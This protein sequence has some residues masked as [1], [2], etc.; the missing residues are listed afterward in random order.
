MNPADLTEPMWVLASFATC[1]ALLFPVRLA[2][3][4]AGVIDRPNARSSHG[5]PTIR[6]A[7][8]GIVLVVA[9]AT[10]TL[11]PRQPSLAAVAGAFVTLAVISFIDDLRGLPARVRFLAH[12]AAAGV[13]LAVVGRMA[14]VDHAAAGWVAGAAFAWVWIV[15][16]TN[17]FNFMDGINGLATIQAIAGSAGTALIA[18]ALGM[19]A[20][21]PLVA[22]SWC[23]TGAS[24]GFLP[25]NFPR[26]RAF[27]GDVGSAP[28]GFL[29]ALLAVWTALETSPW[30]LLWLG[31]LHA[32]FVLDTGVTLLRRAARGER[33]WEAHREHFYQRLVRAGWSHAR[34]TLL[35]AAVQLVAVAVLVWGAAQ[36]AETR[37]LIAMGVVT[38]WLVLFG[39][40][41]AC[42]RRARPA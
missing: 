7:G 42:F 26:A 32:N 10:L 20:S 9:A 30:V 6:G 18:Q 3:G 1:G 38:A 33:V 12:G 24:A 28:L 34:V 16:Y 4:K 8:V 21:H 15:G 5:V 37:W 31:L 13:G 19:E 36:P 2:L 35:Q 22:L 14:E 40:A 17:A 11:S 23:I 27:M 29:L 25:H 39:V 41:E